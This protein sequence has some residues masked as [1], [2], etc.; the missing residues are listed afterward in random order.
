MQLS[1]IP[2][3]L[4]DF[5]LHELTTIQL[6]DEFYFIADEVTAALDYAD[7]KA[8]I[9]KLDAEDKML[10]PHPIRG[11]MYVL[12]TEAAL[13]ELVFASKKPNAKKFQRWVTREVLP[14]IRKKGYYGKVKLP[15]FV[16]RFNL[17]YGRVSRGYFSVISEL[18]IRLYGSLEMLGYEIPDQAQD[19][20]DI[21]PDV[22]VGRLFSNYLSEH[23][24]EHAESYQMYSHMFGNGHTRDARE[25][26]N[27]LLPI[28]IK[29]VDEVWIPSKAKDYFKG[30][31]PVALEYL[32]KLIE[33][34]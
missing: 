8:P 33:V 11:H 29:F 13:Y 9:D 10:S 22:S 6:G 27:E 14:E 12:I 5:N 23:H 20:K 17:N 31:D 28:F 21:R 2:N 4:D 25:Y 3:T 19:G 7:R 32:P 24:P 15:G 26:P 30:R 18:F 34:H 1:I 16:N